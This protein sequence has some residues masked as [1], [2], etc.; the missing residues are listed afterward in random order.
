MFNLS[1]TKSSSTVAL[2]VFNSML[3]DANISFAEHFLVG[4]KWL[5]FEQQD[6]EIRRFDRSTDV[7]SLRAEM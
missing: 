2:V 3:N 6:G 7:C 5:G 4:S 1:Q